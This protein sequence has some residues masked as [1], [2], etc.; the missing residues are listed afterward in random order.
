VLYV[1]LLTS[2]AWAAQTTGTILGTV[3]DQNGAILPGAAMT[4]TNELTNLTRTVTADA[5][6]NYTLPLLPVGKYTMTA[7]LSGFKRYV[8][9]GIVLEVN[10]SARVDITL[11]VGAV[12]EAITVEAGAQLVDTTTSALGEVIEERKMVQLP[13]NERNFLQLGLLQA[14]ITPGISVSPI[15]GSPNPGGVA[16][17]FQVNGLR[18]QANNFLLDGADNND[19]F[20][21]TAAAVPSPDAL[22]E[23]KILTNMYSAEFGHA[24]GAIVNVVTK[25]GTNEFHGN[26]YEFLR[27]DVLDARNFFSEK[28]PKLRRNQFGAT[29][30]GPMVKNKS[31]IF[32]SYEGFRLRQGITK[33]ATVP[34]ALER[35]GNFS[36]SASQ[37]FDFINSQPFPNGV[38]PPNRMN[39]V[40]RRLLQFY[41]LPNRGINQFTSTQDL[42]SD[43]NQF[44]IRLDHS[45]SE[46][47]KFT[48]RY[49]FEEGFTVKPF[50]NTIFGVD[51]SVPGFP[52]KDDFR[53]Q[54][55]VVSDTHVF[56]P[57]LIGDLRVAFNRSRILALVPQFDDNPSDFGFNIPT[58][59]KPNLPLITIAGFTTIGQNNEA[60]SFRHNNIFQYQGSLSYTTGKHSFKT[61]ADIRRTQMNNQADV[62]NPGSYLFLGIFTRNPFADFLLGN[63]LLFLQGGGDSVRNWRFAAYQFYAQD[64]FKV[65]PRLTLNVGLRYELNT[66][67]TDE[68]DRTVAFRPGQQSRVRP[69]TPPGLVFPGDPGVTRSTIQT[70]KNDFGPRLGFSWDV[71]GDGKTSVRGGYGIFYDTLIGLFPNELTFNAP[72]YLVIALV[73][74]PSFENPYQSHNPFIANSKGEFSVAPFSQFEILDRN[75]RSPYVQQWNLTIQRELGKDF[76]AEISYVGTKGTKLI[77]TRNI[78]AARFIPGQSN[79]GNVALRRPFAP[80]YGPLFNYETVFNSSYNGLQ[81]TVN[82]RFSQGFSLLAAYTFS[83]ALDLLSIPI[84]FETTP[85]QATYPQNQNDLRAERGRAA[86]DIRHRFVLSYVVDLPFF[87]GRGGALEKALGG[88]QVSGITTF[89]T[90]SPLTVLDSSDPSL[91]G[92][93]TDR[94]DLVGDPNQGPH[95]VE[96][97]FNTA[98][99]RPVP[100]G[101]GRY[102]NAGRNIVTGPGFNNFDFSLIKEIK[103][104]ETRYF[105]FRAEFF[106]LFNHPNF[107]LPVN[108]IT[109]PNFGQIQNTKPNSERQIQ[110]GL[111]FYF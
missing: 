48:A 18:L 40:A 104:S 20:H 6:G 97:F 64:D 51:V 10:Q 67:G 38:I 55:V 24:G 7:E 58:T 84:N 34:T 73:P 37:P 50:Q 75:I 42:T 56:S 59:Q 16:S 83:K 76:L 60:N 81:F 4:A 111:K 95:R 61:G 39:A 47:N 12:T 87:K 98:A 13:L 35:Q 91:D 110:F 49:Y 62:V 105:Q 80:Q 53:I 41:P 8:R 57:H 90:G 86:F 14:G 17:N 88:W 89:Q 19:P 46:K 94:P 52:H 30:G 100:F 108:D 23:F 69:E 1:G 5:A 27:N 44:T 72:F 31:F 107:D 101:S 82:K 3:K 9:T 63:P 2:S 66:P 28:T 22:Q 15:A 85:G 71:F 79:P 78:N 74:P 29:F 45:F 99:F 68:R 65:R 32:G 36:Q 43:R 109:S 25:S 70:D 92:D 96:R 21:G 11:L 106:D 93:A 103:L 102:G 26:V 33:S 77:G 54:H